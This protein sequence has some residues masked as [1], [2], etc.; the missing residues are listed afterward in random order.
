M[1]GPETRTRSGG[2]ILASAG[3]KNVSAYFLDTIRVFTEIEPF[4]ETPPIEKGAIN[5]TADLSHADNLVLVTM[6]AP[7]DVAH[8]EN[9]SHRGDIAHTLSGVSDPMEDTPA[10]P[11]FHDTPEI[12]DDLLMSAE[13]SATRTDDEPHGSLDDQIDR[14]GDL[15]VDASRFED[16]GDVE[17]VSF[18]DA[19]KSH[20]AGFETALLDESLIVADTVRRNGAR[21]KNLLTR[22]YRLWP[23]HFWPR[24]WRRAWDRRAANRDFV[25]RAK[26]AAERLGSID[27]DDDIEVLSSEMRKRSR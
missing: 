2:K 27:D 12:M 15:D 16:D 21:R 23:D 26:A 7:T 6:D 20:D 1:P 17:S 10:D 18:S 13:P 5:G 4:H 8:P 19:V 22:K 24:S 14:Q 3:Q 25:R 11:L 9:A